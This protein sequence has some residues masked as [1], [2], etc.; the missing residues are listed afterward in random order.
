MT[1]PSPAAY[2]TVAMRPADS[3]TTLASELPMEALLSCAI[4]D[5]AV[6]VLSTC[7]MTCQNAC[8]P[9]AAMVGVSNRSVEPSSSCCMLES[10][11]PLE[12]SFPAKIR[13]VPSMMFASVH[14]TPCEVQRAS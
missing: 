10:A 2:G 12:F 5:A 8:P 13:Q 7:G 6:T 9:T 4:S 14:T 3:Y 11:S 1:T